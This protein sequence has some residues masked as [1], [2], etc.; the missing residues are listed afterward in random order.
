[1]LKLEEEEYITWYWMLAH[2]GKNSGMYGLSSVVGPLIGKYFTVT[3][4]STFKHAN[5]W[6]IGGAFVDNITWR[7]VRKRIMVRQWLQNLTHDSVTGLLAK[8]YTRRNFLHHPWLL[9]PW[10]KHYITPK[11]VDMGQDQAY[12]CIGHYTC[13]CYHLLPTMCSQLGSYGKYQQLGLLRMFFRLIQQN[14]VWLG[15]WT[16]G[17]YLC[18]FRSLIHRA[19]FCRGQGGQRTGKLIHYP[20]TNRSSDMCH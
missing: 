8:H 17:W 9:F 15:W 13:H 2:T 3:R 12:W 11:R 6:I 1:M 16:C 19:C 5:V 7:W 4:L 10:I 14:I 20:N 18:C